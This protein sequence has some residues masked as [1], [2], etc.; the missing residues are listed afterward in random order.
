MGVLKLLLVVAL[1]M[2]GYHWWHKHRDVFAT[3][4][5]QASDEAGFV[6]VPQPRGTSLDRVLIFAP[7]DC[8]SAEAQR[9]RELSQALADHGV[10]H[11]LLDQADF[12]L[13][14]PE[15]AASVH[16]VME[17]T[18]PIV[19]VHGRGKANPTL[20]EVLAEYDAAGR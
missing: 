7:R 15:Q 14:S 18:I 10:P 5:A 19:F 12:D 13:Q 8:P 3:N 20:D 11:G 9:A 2:V 17:G 6:P 4:G 1:V 16:R